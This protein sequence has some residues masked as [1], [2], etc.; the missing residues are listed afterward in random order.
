MSPSLLAADQLTRRDV[1]A[2]VES[3][4]ALRTGHRV[5]HTDAVVGLLFFEPSVRT[6]V[7]FEVAATRLGAHSTVL[8]A[9]KQSAAMWSPET[10][11]DTVRS[12]GPWLDV[13]CLRHPTTGSVAQA[14]ELLDVPLINCGDG[15]G[16]HPTQALIDLFAIAE[17]VG[18]IDRLRIGLVGDLHA[19][20]SAHSLA[21]ALAV[22]EDV[23]LRCMAPSGLELPDGLLRRLRDRGHVVEERSD[24]D[25][26]DLDIVYMAGLPAETRVGILQPEEQSALR[27]TVERA[28]QLGAATH[29]L[30][31][32]PRVDEIDPGVDELP[33]AAYFIQSEM[34]IWVR[35]AVLDHVLAGGLIGA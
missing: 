4:R 12:I 6:R 16:E 31:P 18:P 29:V 21:S 27:M 5:R 22:F 10:L 34:A 26:R 17:L 3:A 30:C 9:V 35:M 13:V 2:L 7:G 25:P 33:Q 8:A 23:H 24:F 15:D 1:E 11:H 20:R 14:A 19:M 32:L 28:H